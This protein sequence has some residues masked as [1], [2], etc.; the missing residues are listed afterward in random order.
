M[1]IGNLEKYFFGFSLLINALF[2]GVA[3]Y[4]LWRMEH[5]TDR[6]SVSM[7][8]SSRL[9]LNVLQAFQGLHKELRNWGLDLK[10]WGKEFRLWSEV[11]VESADAALKSAP[12]LQPEAQDDRLSAVLQRLTSSAGTLGVDK[13]EQL[14][15]ELEDL[16]QLFSADNRASQAGSSENPA[17]PEP[18]QTRES[19]RR[20]IL[21]LQSRLD[22]T[23]RVIYDLRRENRTAYTS[24]A[25]L[26][27]LR[28]TNSK[29][30]AELKNQ[31]DMAQQHESLLEQLHHSLA[32][33]HRGPAFS[34]APAS[35][36]DSAADSQPDVELQSRLLRA[37]TDRA[38]LSAQLKDAD[39][40]MD[41][42]LRE[43][44]MVED[45]LLELLD[46]AP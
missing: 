46:A 24:I 41:R 29:L 25:A 36:S 2:L 13:L 7:D 28:Q 43:K 4:V 35:S 9:A 45:R 40:A 14:T 6:A 33:L 27:T 5:S 34:A 38:K 18:R 19:Q 30:F 11:F 26:E 21:Q 8:H 16:I 17:A 3:V 31:R 23:N 44:K 37:E 10:L 15:E 22:E 1:D 39:A 42:A 32:A 20:E 12:A